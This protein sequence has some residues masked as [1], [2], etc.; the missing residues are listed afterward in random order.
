MDVTKIQEKSLLARELLQ[1]GLASDYE[2]ACR[3]IDD[4]G[5][6]RDTRVPDGP[7]PRK[8][9][10]AAAEAREAPV[11]EGS[12]TTRGDL[13][14]SLAQLKDFVIRYTKNNDRN[15]RELDEKMNQILNKL[16][17]GVQAPL[18]VQKEIE[19]TQAAAPLPAVST[20][21]PAQQKEEHPHPQGHLN[22]NDFSVE[23]YFS[24]S[25]GKMVKK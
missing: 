11:S 12:T 13:D 8:A 18:P 23:K 2:E 9:Y 7:T 19:V 16:N 22:P 10:E 14:K 4:K 17:Q 25:G 21:Q 1:K 5:M 24:N 15:L 6:V 3:M 20:P